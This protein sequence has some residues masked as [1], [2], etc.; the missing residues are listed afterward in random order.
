MEQKLCSRSTSSMST[1]SAQ[2]PNY[3]ASANSSIFSLPMTWFLGFPDTWN[4]PVPFKCYL[5]VSSSEKGQQIVVL[6]CLRNKAS[7]CV[8]LH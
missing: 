5:T 8:P 1:T 7:N 2:E 4:L 6:L 3:S